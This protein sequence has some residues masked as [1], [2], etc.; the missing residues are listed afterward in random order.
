MDKKEYNAVRK[1]Q[2]M[3]HR[4]FAEALGISKEHSQRL[5]Y[6]KGNITG[7]VERLVLLMKEVP[8]D[9]LI[10]QP[11]QVEDKA[12]DQKAEGDS[13]LETKHIKPFVRGESMKDRLVRLGMR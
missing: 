11:E 1:A 3:T 2:G 13:I 10:H 6:G 4:E 7:A 12:P 8:Y 5:A 9:P